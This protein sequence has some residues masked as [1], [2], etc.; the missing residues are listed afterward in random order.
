MF[1]LGNVR[2]SRW[3]G[4]RVRHYC[5]PSLISILG[6]YRD[7]NLVGDS[8]YIANVPSFSFSPGLTTSVD[9]TGEESPELKSSTGLIFKKIFQSNFVGV[10][11]EIVIE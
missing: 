1:K 8:L 2:S 4:E 11:Y 7:W 5:K 6:G 10:K 9:R 3:D